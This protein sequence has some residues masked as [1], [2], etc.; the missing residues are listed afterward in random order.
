MAIAGQYPLYNRRC[1]LQNVG[2]AY[3]K[4]KLRFEM[5]PEQN[6]PDSENINKNFGN[7]R[8]GDR[9]VEDDEDL[10]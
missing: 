9:D 5:F 6:I 10:L 2:Q 3:D 7:T 8:W 4:L 1:Y